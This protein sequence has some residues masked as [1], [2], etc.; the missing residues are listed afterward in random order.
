MTL[1]TP[2]K[3]NFPLNTS[4]QILTHL[5]ALD[6]TLPHLGEVPDLCKGAQWKQDLA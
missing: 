6:E 5:T 1:T 4:T 2:V 3:D